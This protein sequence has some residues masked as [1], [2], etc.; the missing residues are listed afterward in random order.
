MSN[1]TH[2]SRKRIPLHVRIWILFVTSLP[3]LALAQEKPVEIHNR[4][5]NLSSS[6]NQIALTLDACSGKFDQVLIDFLIENQIP[7]TLFLTKRWIIQNPKGSTLIKNHLDLFDIE[8]HGEHHIPAVIGVGRRIY[9]ILVEPDLDHLNR[10]IKVGAEAIEDQFGVKPTWYRGAGAVYDQQSIERITQLDYKIAGFSINADEGATLSAPMIEK[11]L[12]HAQA[13]DVIIA[14]MNR[15]KSGTAQGLK[16]A[17]TWLI[18]KG[19]V[20]VRLSEIQVKR[21]P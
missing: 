7:A 15:P 13:G 12:K 3:L 6:E 17:L 1:F 20:F 16:G 14:H 2:F 11:R 18:D 19:F 5:I 9:G 10:E 21:I 8:N 4:I